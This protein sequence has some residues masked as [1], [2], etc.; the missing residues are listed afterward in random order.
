MKKMFSTVVKQ[1]LLGAAMRRMFIALLLFNATA[2]VAGTDYYAK[3]TA[4]V[5]DTGGGKVYVDQQKNEPAEAKYQQPEFTKNTTSK[6]EEQKAYLYAM[7]EPGYYFVDWRES[8]NL[9]KVYSTI[10]KGEE[11]TVNA[12]AS[13]DNPSNRVDGGTYVAFFAPV[14]VNRGTPA[15]IQVNDI[16]VAENS[17]TT[18]HTKTGVVAFSVT[19]ADNIEDF[20]TPTIAEVDGFSYQGMEYANGVLSVTIQYQDQN[21][22]NV[23]PG[24]NPPLQ[25]TV[26]LRSKGDTDGSKTQS[27]VVSAYSSL[28][29]DFTINPS[30]GKSFIDLTPNTPM[31]NDATLTASF[32]K[33]LD[34]AASTPTAI[35]VSPKNNVANAGQWSISFKDAADAANKGFSISY[36]VLVSHCFFFFFFF[37]FRQKH[38]S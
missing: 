8:T 21:I 30:E 31:S 22:D 15:S 29:P 9:G 7:S 6:S 18:A 3:F 32:A 37:F 33:V 10:A 20:Y 23:N 28:K 11:V 14:L 34:G 2:A 4:K 25:T 1:S 5:A 24:Y 35:N 12:S 38:F 19:G 27:A 16:Y 26:T 36:T 17:L 13:A